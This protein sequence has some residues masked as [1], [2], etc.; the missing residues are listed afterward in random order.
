MPPN[1]GEILAKADAK[2]AAIDEDYEM[3]LMSQEERHKQV[4]D[5]WNE[6]NEEVGEAMAENFDKFN[7]IYMMAFSGARGNIKQ[8]R[9]LAG[10][11]GLMSDPKGEIIDRPIK[12]NFREG[13][14]VLEYF[15][16]THGA[17]KGLADTA[18]R[19]ADS[20]Y[21]T[22]RLVDVAQ[23]V[24]IREIDCG[25]NDGVPYPIYNE[26]GDL[27]E[28]LIGRCLL[29]DAVAAD[30][31][32]VVAGGEYVTS[33]AQ[34]KALED[35]GITEVV[36]RTVMTCHADHGVC[37]KCYGWDLATSR[38]VNIGTAVGIIAAQ[39]IGEPG[40]QLTMRTF[41]TG[42]VAGEDITHGL[43]RVQELFEARKPK[44][45]AVL[46][47]ISGTMQISGDKQSKTITI[48]DQEG[49]F[50]EYVVSARA[51]L[52]PG[53][54]DGCEVHVGQQLTK[55]SVNPHDL[56]RLTDPNTTLRYIVGQVQGVYVSQGVDIND[57]HIEVIAR[58]MLRKVA[59]M[60]AGDS[61]LLPGRQVNRFEFERI[62]NE[63]IAEGKEPP[64][65]QPLL[66]GI[67]KASLATDSFLSAASF[68]E[69][70][71]VLTD[72]ANTRSRVHLAGLKENVIIG[73]PIPAGTGPAPLPRRAPDLQGP[74]RGKGDGRCAARLRAGCA[75]R[76]RGLAA[77]AAGLV[78]RRR[79][80]PQHGLQ[81][82]QLLQRPFAGAPR[83][84]PVRRGGSPV[85]LRRLGRVAALGQQVLR[86]GHRDGGRLAG[87]YRG[88]PA[89]HRGHWREGHRGVEGRP[90]RARPVACDRGRLG[91]H[92][93]RH[94]AA[95]RHGVQ[96]RRHHPHR[97]RRAAHVRHVGRGHAG[98]GPAAAF[99]PAQ[100]GR[101]R[102]ASGFG[103]SLRLRA[104][105]QRAR[106]SRRRRGIRN[107]GAPHTGGAPSLKTCDLTAY[108][109]F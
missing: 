17:R 39:S 93:R 90:G 44:G 83:A 14:S 4:V 37:Q 49:N 34:V 74:S 106:G 30:G 59:V 62:A 51:Q 19:T 8:I 99:L 23:D 55:G 100:S 6:A 68:Q 41:H 40:T 10:M 16:S 80:L 91:G 31:T 32:V 9:Q 105:Q 109:M 81:L 104:Y 50:R 58:Q 98:R 94:V 69:T 15:I 13:L 89:A 71:K 85:H 45:Q 77:A 20:G 67:T 48:H 33:M 73:K 25:T 70:T 107:L 56:L 38:P 108:C 61:D 54:S 12:A 65:G 79:G 26:K 76:H 42:G 22:R 52:L 63:L 27:D 96:P 101:T 28:N 88:R 36:I 21:L 60:D 78:A 66:L 7:P 29:E 82:R 46:A 1:K 95:A 18:L 64:V 72:A 24:I 86:G 84:Q 97:R 102:R 53:V 35:A 2:V 92:E 57:K 75:A 47:E 103:G 5:I 11:R 3:G 87:P 43:P